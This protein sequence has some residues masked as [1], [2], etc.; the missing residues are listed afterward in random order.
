MK[1]I[2][3]IIILIGIFISNIEIDSHDDNTDIELRGVFISYIE[4]NNY[5]KGKSV[6]IAHNNIDS[7]IKNI[8]DMKL[9]TIILQVRS[10]CDSI[11]KSSIFP[12]SLYL[13]NSEKDDYFD[14]L[15]YFI[16]NCHRNNIKLFAWINPY[17]IRTTDNIDSI[18]EKS[19]AYKY[20]NTDT[21]YINNGIYFNPSKKEVTD[22][23]VSGVKEILK[24]EV[25]GILFDDY[26][27][28]S[29][30]IDLNDYNKYV[31]N[32]DYI[33][34]EDYHYNVINNMV[35]KVHEVCKNKNVLFGI[36]PDGNIDNNYNSNFADVK[37]WMSS[38]K[39][40]D[41]IMP[42][43]YYGFYNTTRGF[44]K[45]SNEWANLL[46]NDNVKLYIAL[47]FYKIGKVDRK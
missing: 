17:R 13:V 4:L 35:L 45:V 23:I 9:N 18:S 15:D 20:I 3:I 11:Y 31:E 27:Y 32:N 29:N 43:L 19:P 47:A 7:M 14:V 46:K 28:P 24:Y 42:Q 5:L 33:S 10:S 34:I 38:D 22:L 12:T 8:K 36:S 41:F 26:F 37:K 40:I 2:I 6:D 39:Y 25:D 1:K 44:Y 21:I 16:K 30:D